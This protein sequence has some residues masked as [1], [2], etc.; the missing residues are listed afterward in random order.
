MLLLTLMIFVFAFSAPLSAAD[1]SDVDDNAWYAEAVDYCSEKGYFKGTSE[2]TFSPE[3]SMDRSMIVTVLHRREG[4][5]EPQ[6]PASFEDVSADTWYTDAVAWAAENGIVFGYEDGSFRP[7]KPVT[8][9]EIMAFFQRYVVY[10]GKTATTDDLRIYQSFLDTSSVADWSRPAV[11]W[12]TSVGIICGSNGY[13]AP[14]SVSTRAQIASVLMRLDAYTEGR[15][16]TI[17]STY[18]DGGVVVPLGRFEI[19]E[20]SSVT[21]RV[22]PNSGWIQKSATLNETKLTNQWMYVVYGKDQPQTLTVTFRKLAGNPYG[23]YGQL[24][25]R[26]YPIPNASSYYISDLKKVKNGNVQL[27]AEAADA[28]DRMVAAFT[29]NL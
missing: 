9:E 7:E 27:R 26:T 3:Q 19:V 2:S 16:D 21:F 29:E 23:G 24:V 12:C 13:I 20:G 11:Q 15:T 18:G 22:T 6:T 28:M 14:S 5:P 25:N 1:F 4:S 17:I 8:R 10:L